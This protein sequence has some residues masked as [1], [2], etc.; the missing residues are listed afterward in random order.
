ME[1]WI[2]WRADLHHRV[3]APVEKSPLPR[4]LDVCVGHWC[5]VLGS[6]GKI[7]SVSSSALS[8]PHGNSLL[9]VYTSHH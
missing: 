7:P 6:A 4:A 3:T 5:S 1:N 8:R 2:S 9:F